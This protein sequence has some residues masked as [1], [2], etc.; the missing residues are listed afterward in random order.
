MERM[1]GSERRGT[2]IRAMR[3]EARV[4]AN[5]GK[6]ELQSRWEKVSP[7][8]QDAQRYAKEISQAS[9]LAAQDVWKR[10]KALRESWRSPVRSTHTH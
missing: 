4:R 2:Q 3:D 1:E 10:F 6:K 5:L 8:L 9:K 7:R